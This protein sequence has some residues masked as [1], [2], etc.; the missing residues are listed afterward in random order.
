[1][2][3]EKGSNQTFVALLD[4]GSEL[5]M[6]PGGLKEASGPPVTVGTYGGPI[7]NGVPSKSQLTVGPAVLEP[8]VQL[9]PQFQNVYLGKICG[10]VRRIHSL[11][12]RLV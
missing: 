5:T 1:M 4:A 12:P 10:E 9:L 7:V 2:P 3:W 11:V 6:I 8:N